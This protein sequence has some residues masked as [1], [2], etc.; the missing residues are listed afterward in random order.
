MRAVILLVPLLEVVSP[1]TASSI[2]PA[3]HRREAGDGPTP[4]LLLATEG[5]ERE[6]R[7]LFELTK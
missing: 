3:L 6:A 5:G 1:R 4:I 2:N 7:P